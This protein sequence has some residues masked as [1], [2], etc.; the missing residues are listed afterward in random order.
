MPATLTRPKR[1]SGKAPTGAK[2]SRRPPASDPA[3]RYAHDVVSGRLIAG[4]LVRMACQRH[5]DDLARDDLVWNKP[6]A[7][8]AIG[9]FRDVLRLNGGEHEGKPFALEPFECFLVGS[10]FGWYGLDGY[11]RFRVAYVE[12]AKGNG[13][14]PIAAGVGHYMLKADKEP[15]AEVY[16]AAT[17]KD[18]AMILFRDAV[19]M[20]EQSPALSSRL[21]LSGQQPNV[22]NIADLETGSFFR[23]IASDDAQSGPRPHC[24]LIDEVHEHKTPLM[25]DMMRAGTKGRRQALIFEITNSGFDRHS[26]CRQHHEYSEKVLQGILEDDSWFAYVCGLDP[27]EACRAKGN[28]QPTDNCPDCDDWKDEKVWVKANPNLGVSV[29]VKYLREQVREAVGMPAKQNIVRRLNFCQWT[30][31]DERWL[32]MALWDAGKASI[33]LAALRGRVCYAGLDLARVNDL[34]ALALVFPPMDATE[35]WKVLVRYWVPKDDIGVR[36]K[37][38]RVPYDVWVRDGL[39]TATPG[40]ATDF[41]FIQAAILDAAGVYTIKEVA[42]DRTFAGEI[43]Q[44]LMAEG[45]TMVPFG[46]GFL[47]MGPPTA[48]LHRLLLSANLEHTGDPVTRWC[49]S[50]VTVAVDAANNIK[51]D[52]ERSTEKIDGIVA[53]CNA[54]GRAMVQPP[55]QVSAYAAR[56]FV[57]A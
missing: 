25:I 3:T 6:Q 49:A 13:K 32:D 55:P 7:T 45:L 56:G 20:V 18:Q 8:R 21:K 19:A 24:A 38:D 16:A 41:G 51:P 10:L 31:Q 37:R 42:Y 29:T 2:V 47:S 11:R 35:R 26:V 48:E 52:K 14:S 33:D 22:W 46:Q 36:V 9:Y 4:P 44:N 15:R 34:S 53:I 12:I 39:I 57:S 28:L 50:N 1:T 30:E 40:N 5:L 27:C 17:K 43:V 54:L 23:P